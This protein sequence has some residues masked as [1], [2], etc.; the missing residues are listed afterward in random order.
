MARLNVEKFL[1]FNGW[2][3][4]VVSKRRNGYIILY[5]ERN[6]YPWVIMC[7]QGDLLRFGTESELWDYAIKNKL[8]KRGKK[9]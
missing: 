6:I 5:C 3:Y 2:E 7:P 1:N 8:F 4:E 9:K